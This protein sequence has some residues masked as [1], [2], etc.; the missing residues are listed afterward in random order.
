MRT[1][2][3]SLQARTTLY[4]AFGFLFLWIIV[5]LVFFFNFRSALVSSFDDQLKARASIVALKTNI[6]PRIVPLPQGDE[7]FTLVYVNG[8]TPDTLFKPGNT[9]FPYPADDD[10]IVSGNGWRVARIRQSL[11]NGGDLHVTFA[12]PAS[13][14][15]AQLGSMELL[16]ILVLPAGLILAVV[17]AYWLSYTLL[18]PVKQVINL[19]KATNI[20][21]DIE[22]LEE[23]ETNDELKELIV[24][25][26]RMLLRIKD[27]TSRQ[28]AF[29]ASASHE[30]RTPLSVMHTRLELLI[31]GNT[32]TETKTV[33]AEQLKEVQQMTKMV[34]DFLLLSEIKNGDLR[35]SIGSCDLS[36]IITET[37][38][39]YRAGSSAKKLLFR[40]E[41]APV[42]ASYEVQA[43]DGWL[44]TIFSNLTEN[45]VKYAAENTV[46]Q[47]MMVKLPNEVSVKISNEIRYD[48][49]PDLTELKTE[50]YHSKP[51]HGE[52]FGLGLW[53]ADQLAELQHIKLSFDIGEG[54]IFEARILI[55]S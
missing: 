1:R 17:L 37:I 26:N 44:R 51:L 46:I 36:E 8:A 45:A 24:S 31:R 39:K 34:N 25:F 55:N 3:I 18:R 23:P 30:L 20:N 14:I 19:A 21:D 28:T 49:N 7:S 9:A 38:E 2:Q 53:I 50:F 52:G 35:V 10:S 40:I 43:D 27:Q 12:L 16:L 15:N 4:F 47:V 5:S 6:S 41:Y 11:E 22:L 48:V 54:K 32:N 29:F 13:G 33:Y 42:E